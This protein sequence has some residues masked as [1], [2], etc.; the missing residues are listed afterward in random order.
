MVNGCGTTFYG[1]KNRIADEQFEEY[2]TTKWF[3]LIWLPIAPLGSYRIRRPV[4]K[5]IIS[6]IAREGISKE[7]IASVPR[8]FDL[9]QVGWIYFC[10]YGW[11]FIL[12]AVLLVANA[13]GK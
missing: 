13:F 12:L 9:R 3:C 10:V 6:R 7:T 4:R 5:D 8:E 11:Y 2:D 1:V